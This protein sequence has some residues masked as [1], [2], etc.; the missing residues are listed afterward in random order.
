MKDIKLFKIT[1]LLVCCILFTGCAEEVIDV[2]LETAPPKLVIEASIDWVKNTNG[3]QQ[4]IILST[5]TGY[6]NVEFPTVSGASISITNS[7][8][9]NFVFTETSSSGEYVCI[10]FDPII[11]ETYTLTV[12]LNG[13]TYKATETLMEA[14]SIDEEIIQNSAGGVTGDEMEIQFS[15][16]D[17]ANQENYYMTGIKSTRI[18]YP[19]YNLESDERY[20]GKKMTQFYSNKD[21]KPGDQMEIKLYGTS[22]RFFTYFKKIILA[23]GNDDGPFATTPTAVRG[24]IVNQTNSSNF[25]YGYFRLS[26][27]D[28]KN[29]T[30]K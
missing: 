18:A 15:F 22:K 4:K 24:N 6:Y 5:S 2:E 3:N 11:G 1:C 7:Q 17:I 25:P 30:I 19:E 21:F 8:N 13:E 12:L 14:P 28:V 9:N 29:Y 20:E 27:V 23:T 26:E 16:Q 10:N